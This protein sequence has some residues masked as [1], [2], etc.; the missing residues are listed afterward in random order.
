MKQ[1]HL[2]PYARL[3]RTYGRL[4]IVS[5]T[6][7]AWGRAH[8]L[9]AERLP[10]HAGDD[11]YDAVVV[12]ADDGGIQETHLSAALPRR[13][14]L[15]ALPDGGFVLADCRSRK[16]EEHAQVFDALG[17]PSWTFRLGDGIEHLIAD[18]AGELW[19][20]YF[21]EGVYGDDPL[22]SPGLRRFSCTGE[23]LWQFQPGP[24]PMD[25]SDC[26]ALNV[27]SR[28]AWACPY[29]HF[30]LLEIRADE[31][32]KVRTTPVKG[33]KGLAVHGE[34]VTFFGGYQDEH[35]R[36]TH[37]RLTDTSVEPAGYGQLV[38]PDGS[39]LGRRQVV[40]RGPRIYVREKASPTQWTVLDISG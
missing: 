30:P 39:G 34:R 25:M 1:T 32:V 26:Y 38:R 10:A 35:D 19:V 14:A 9:L 21:D 12:T 27:G 20:G 4:E 16:D 11:P 17:R 22:S 5:S 31:R 29:T 24:G 28:A 15:D 33:P 6:V 2:T 18:E 7:D 40:C 3:P 13:P 23:P 37:G 8:W 36:L